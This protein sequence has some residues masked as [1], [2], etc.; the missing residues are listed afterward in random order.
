MIYGS[1]HHGRRSYLF[2]FFHHNRGKEP[3]LTSLAPSGPTI[4]KTFV[5]KL[6]ELE[7][8]VPYFK[9]FPKDDWRDWER[10]QLIHTTCI[11]VLVLQIGARRTQVISVI[12][13]NS[14]KLKIF[15]K[16]CKRKLFFSWRGTWWEF[17]HDEKSCRV[18]YRGLPGSCD[19]EYKNSEKML[20]NKSS[21]RWDSSQV[22]PSLMSHL[23]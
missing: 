6:Q 15:G 1:S 13:V 10:A 20:C 3:R 7:A 21:N 5:A 19:G 14:E 18:H 17:L 16:W 12:L 9:N 4:Y 22:L 2:I 8:L 23:T 11:I